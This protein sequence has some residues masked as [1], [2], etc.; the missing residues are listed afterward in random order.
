MA[1][2]HSPQVRSYNMSR[3]RSKNTKPEELVRKY[4]FSHGLRYRKNDKRYPGNPDMVFPKYKTALFVNGC[5]WHS[6]QGCSDFVMPKSRTDYWEAKLERNRLRD[7]ENIVSLEANGW[8]VLV[9]W[10]CELKKANQLA[11]LERLVED[12][13]R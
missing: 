6:H 8:R 1:D 5:F 4:L 2:N 7:S 12:L 13:K 10:E 9:V 3:I 11:T